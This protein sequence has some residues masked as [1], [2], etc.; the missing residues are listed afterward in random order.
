[1]QGGIAVVRYKDFSDYALVIN[2]E[3]L[4]RNNGN[5]REIIPLFRCCLEAYSEFI[6][7]VMHEQRVSFE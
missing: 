3:K 7:S 5:A 2:R 6:Q 1:M 4:K